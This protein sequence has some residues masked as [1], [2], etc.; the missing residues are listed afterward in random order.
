[1]NSSTARPI[2]DYHPLSEVK[3]LMIDTYRCLESLDAMVVLLP[4]VF[5]Q[6]QKI[7]AK[8]M[9]S[10]I[11]PESKSTETE[12]HGEEFFYAIQNLPSYYENENSEFLD[13]RDDIDIYE[14]Y[15][16]KDLLQLNSIYRDCT[17]VNCV[18]T[19]PT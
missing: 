15:D 13:S 16:V 7:Q 11:W 1:M 10:E 2:Y 8:Q 3:N 5:G 9:W 6:Y 18:G 17:V 14:E 4:G 19:L 12:A